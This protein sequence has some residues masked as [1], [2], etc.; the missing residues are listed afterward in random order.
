MAEKTKSERPPEIMDE[1]SQ[2]EP[3]IIKIAKHPRMNKRQVFMLVLFMII[4]FFYGVLTMGL[5]PIG[6]SIEKVYSVSEGYMH[7]LQLTPILA[8]VIGFFPTFKVLNKFGLKTGF[9]ICLVFSFVGS[10]FELLIDINPYFFF[11]GHF[12]IL[13]GMQSI[14][15]AKG[16]FV[17]I[18]FEERNVRGNNEERTSFNLDGFCDA[19]RHDHRQCGSPLARIAF[20]GPYTLRRCH[21]RPDPSVHLDQGRLLRGVHLARVPGLLQVS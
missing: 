15:T 16:L 20:T 8:A 13:T 11:L 3:R 21:Q 18:F 10:F 4:E 9:G 7:L 1:D 6:P 17:N 14:H 12:L 5:G 19:S 2:D